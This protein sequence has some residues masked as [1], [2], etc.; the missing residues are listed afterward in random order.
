MIRNIDAYGKRGRSA[1]D[2]GSEDLVLIKKKLVAMQLGNN[3]IT[4]SINI[5]DLGRGTSKS[6]TR[7]KIK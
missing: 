1:D 6:G 3:S 2:N 4:D 7:Y 5:K